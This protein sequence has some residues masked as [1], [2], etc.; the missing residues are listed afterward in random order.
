MLTEYIYLL[1]QEDSVLMDQVLLRQMEGHCIQE[2]P[3]LLAKKDK[4]L[5]M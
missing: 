1:Q 5:H 4:E 2:V 3:L